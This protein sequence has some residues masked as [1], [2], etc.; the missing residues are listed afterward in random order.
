MEADGHVLIGSYD[1]V[2]Q[3]MRLETDRPIALREAIM[4]CRSGGT[5]SVPGVYGGFVDKIPF[6]TVVN[7]SLTIKSGQTHV[8]KYMR[9]LLQRI[10]EG[11]IDPAYIITHRLPLDQG[12]EGYELFAKNKNDCIKV[13]LSP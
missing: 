1:R 13:V 7:R 5:V 9:P 10:Q 11:Q 6:G 8:Q 3:A 2:K 4:N 12:P